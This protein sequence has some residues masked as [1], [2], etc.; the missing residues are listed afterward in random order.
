M[1]QQIR[2]RKSFLRRFWWIF[3]VILLLAGG[4]IFYTMKYGSKHSS[5]DSGLPTCPADLSG[6]LTARIMDQGVIKALTPLGNSNPPGHTFPVDH[7]YFDGLADGIKKNIYAPGNGKILEIQEEI[8]FDANNNIMRQGVTITIGLCQGVEIV[9]ASPGELAANLSAE[10]KKT[11][12]SCKISNGKH[13]NE[14]SIKACGYNLQKEVKAGDLI[15]RTDGNDFPE[16]WA[17]D[18]NKKLSADV[19]WERYDSKYYPYAMCMFDLY[20]GELKKEYYSLFGSFDSMVQKDNNDKTTSEK[21]TFTARTMAPLCGQTIQN[22]VGTVQGDWF[23]LPKGSDTFP[24]QNIGDLALIHDNLDPTIGKIVV[25]GNISN[26]G[27]VQF[28]PSNSGTINRDF[29]Q[30][31]ADGQIYCYQDDPKV[32]LGGF[33]IE[34]KFLIQLADD[35][36]LK[37]ENQNGICSNNESFNNPITY[38]R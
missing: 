23:G 18:H 11:S 22:I 13:E 12:G 9:I 28:I 31:K 33:K 16:V 36:H 26:A 17:L 2:P 7:N 8:C 29:S 25:A 30:V 38:E 20:S 14:K 27:V 34:G 1:D 37:I 21:P 15:A 3:V 24:G 5:Y 6:I 10:I 32:Q 19:D 4:I 35:H